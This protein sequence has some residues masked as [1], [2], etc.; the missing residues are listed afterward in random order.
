MR[1]P[2]CCNSG[3][4]KGLV[5]RGGPSYV[6]AMTKVLIIGAGHAGGTLAVLL[7]QYGFEGGIV[8]A[9]TETAPP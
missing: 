8:V 4:V 5:I 9:G 7:R 3:T 6:R 2:L 1:V